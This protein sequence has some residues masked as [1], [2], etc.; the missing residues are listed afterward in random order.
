M[1][2]AFIAQQQLTNNSTTSVTFSNIPNT[3]AD[4][5]LV[6]RARSYNFSDQNF[7]SFRLNNIT[8]ANYYT[9]GWSNNF[10][11]GVDGT[12]S[13][14]LGYVSG[15]SSSNSYFGS[16]DLYLT[17]YTNTS[18]NKGWTGAGGHGWGTGTNQS[19][20]QVYTGELAT[21]NAITS[22]EIYSNQAMGS[23]SLFTLYGIV[24][25]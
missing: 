20:I 6:Y 10:G 22:I 18:F 24:D 12:T 5:Y 16:G 11:G 17:K 3:Y 13:A 15:N 8:T 1:S 9:R 23:G 21:T 2:Y 19:Y 4:L 14:A 7:L 25:S